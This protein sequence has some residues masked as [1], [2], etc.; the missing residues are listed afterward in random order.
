MGT[1][2]IFE[3]DFD[4]LTVFK[5]NKTDFLRQASEIDV[6]RVV[7]DVLIY[8][9]ETEPLRLVVKIVHC[10]VYNVPV[11]YFLAFRS[12]TLL[13]CDECWKL[14]FD[15]QD[16]F[17]GAISFEQLPNQPQRMIRIHPCQNDH[18]VK[19]F[20]ASKNQL[21]SVL[22]VLL[23]PFFRFDPT[24]AGIINPVLE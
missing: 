22:S 12:D 3:S 8:E 15:E 5:M 16:S 19:Q 10:E 17:V 24:L 21:R 23:Q 6:F 13:S 18:F 20:Q 1:H 14:V 2:P 11:V 9:T 7:D 4:C